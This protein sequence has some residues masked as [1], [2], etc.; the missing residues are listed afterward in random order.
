MDTEGG[1]WTHIQKRF[2]GSVD[3][4]QNWR[5]YKFGFGDLNGEFWLGLEHIHS[6]TGNFEE[7]CDTQWKEEYCRS[8]VGMSRSVY[9]CQF[10]SEAS[11]LNLPRNCKEVQSRGKNISGLYEIQPD[12]NRNSIM[13]FCDM[14]IRG[15]G[16]T[17]IHKRFD[18]SVDFFLG[19]R[20]YKFG[21]GDLN[22]EF[23][24]GLENIHLLTGSD[25][26]ELLVELVARDNTYA[27]AIYQEFR[28]GSEADGYPLEGLA[29]FS[30]DAGDS[31][32]YH[33]GMKFTTK[34]VDQDNYEGHNCADFARGGYWYN[35]CFASNLNG[36]LVNH[37]E[38]VNQA[39]QGMTW[40]SFKARSYV[41]SRARMLI[42][43]LP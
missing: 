42:R 39:R 43:P 32:K 35:N 13:A 12:R 30:G 7:S 41:L 40:D 36:G 4:Y 19:W 2:D 28:I 37:E 10:A 8:K 17:H 26:N 31:L 1:G 20:E 34:D 11:N 38:P 23:W 18:G 14:V 5:E 22:G 25:R 21:F 6:M 9:P 27:Y 29:G 33:V 16:W 3:F 15:G 24:L